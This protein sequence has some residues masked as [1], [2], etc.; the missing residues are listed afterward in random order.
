M[1]RSTPVAWYWPGVGRRVELN[2]PTALHSA[3]WKP[4][5]LAPQHGREAELEAAMHEA[6]DA[7]VEINKSGGSHRTE[8]EAVVAHMRRALETSAVAQAQ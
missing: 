7:L 6:I 4:L 3:N 5:Y 1:N 8:L 2:R